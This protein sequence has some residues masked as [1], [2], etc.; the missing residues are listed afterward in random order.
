MLKNKI[1]E[2][3]L[4]EQIKFLTGGTLIKYNKSSNNIKIYNHA[5]SRQISNRKESKN[6]NK[7]KLI[8]RYNEIEE[9]KLKHRAG[10]VNKIINPNP[11]SSLNSFTN[12]ALE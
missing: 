7:N 1:G 11:N 2:N 6:T 10:I 5:K 9:P 12:E 3:R 4:R 8:E